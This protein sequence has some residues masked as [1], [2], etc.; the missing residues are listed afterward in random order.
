VGSLALCPKHVP[1]L[2]DKRSGGCNLHWFENSHFQRR[3]VTSGSIEDV[4]KVLNRYMNLA[5]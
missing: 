1:F 2:N 5:L 3:G 4:S